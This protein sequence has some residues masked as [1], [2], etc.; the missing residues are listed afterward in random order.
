MSP[1]NG[2]TIDLTVTSE[3]DM[4]SVNNNDDK[5]VLTIASIENPKQYSQPAAYNSYYSTHTPITV[6][7]A[8]SPAS[9]K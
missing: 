4:M 8:V 1:K 9:F 6:E 5:S 2:T 7:S 3:S